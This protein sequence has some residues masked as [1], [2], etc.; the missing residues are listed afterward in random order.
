MSSYTVKTGQNIYD[1]ALALYGSIEGI[2]DLLV[3]N[4]GLS[5]NDTLEKGQELTYHEDFIINQ[6]IVDSL[7]NSRIVVKNGNTQMQDTDVAS[8]IQTWVEA[9]NKNALEKSSPISSKPLLPFTPLKASASPVLPPQPPLKYLNGYVDLPTDTETFYT[10]TAVPK[11]LIKQSGSVTT[12]KAQVSSGKFVAFDWGDGSKLDFYNYASSTT[13]QH[14]YEDSG[15]H[16]ILMYGLTSF[17][18]LDI[19]QISGM[20]YALAQF[21]ITGEFKSPYPTATTL[22]QLFTN[23]EDTDE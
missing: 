7:S 19:S 3:S 6:D 5:L 23:K 16:Q 15:E 8:A 4:N 13:I 10:N 18:N 20:Y 21:V 22:N 17:T 11:L 2:F 9:N 12:I 1:V 14:S